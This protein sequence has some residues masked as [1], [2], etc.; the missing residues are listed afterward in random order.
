M[1]YGINGDI[2]I[3]GSG[4]KLN[5]C[6]PVNINTNSETKTNE[7]IDGKQ[8]YT[9]RI[10]CGVPPQTATKRIAH[11]IKG[12]FEI[13]LDYS[14]SFLTSRLIDNPLI[15]QTSPFTNSRNGYNVQI[16][17]D[18]NDIVITSFD[19]G[20]GNNWEIIVVLKYIYK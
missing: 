16:I 1:N 8:V 18:K 3:L 11:N 14:N 9:K 12:A 20:W 19:S 6:L 15:F 4:K 13:W 2:P 17:I 10:N 5:D 7:F